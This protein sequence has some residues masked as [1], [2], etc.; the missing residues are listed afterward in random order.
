MPDV[1]RLLALIALCLGMSV[2]AL[3]GESPLTAV[4]GT[5]WAG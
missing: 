3:A 5:G 2:P 4:A 1:T